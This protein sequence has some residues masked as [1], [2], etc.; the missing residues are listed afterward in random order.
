MASFWQDLRYAFRAFGKSP[1]FASLAVVTL[2]LGIA[3]NTSIFSIINGFLMR[4]MPVPHPEQLTVLSL[5][6]AG[7]KSLQSFS[8]PDYLDLRDQSSSF[9][10]IIA[11][12]V[13][14]AGL[15][16]D[17]RGDHCIATRVTGNYFS[18]LGVQPALGRLILP[19]EGQTPGAD[20]ILVLGYSYWQ[21]RF[22]G[23]K[24]V[25]GKQVEANGHPLT[26]VGVAPKEF[27]G[28]YS[29][30]DSDLYV[31]LS[32]SI[33]TKDEK[34]VENTWMQ[35][36]ERSLS[37]MARLKPGTKL[38]NAQASLDVVAQR[39]AEQ[40]P[41][42]DKGIAIRA[43]PEQLARPEPD[44]DN[45]LPSVAL[46]F[47]ALAALVL[48]VACFN[49][50]NV[51]LVRA[52][53]RQREMAIRAALGAGRV[54]LVRQYLTE[55]LLLALLGA[56]GGMLL[57]YWAM[58]FLSSIPLGT[59]LPLQL[60]FLPD[61]RVYFFALGAALVAGVI[62]GVFPALRVARHDVS[63]VLHDGGRGSSGGRRRQFLRGSLV[64]AQVAGSLV[65]LIVAGLFIRSLG[66]A[67]NIY[68]GFESSQVLDFSLDVQQIG[69]QESQGRAFYR[70]LESR[71]RALPGVVSVAQAFSVP[72]GVMSTFD[73][74]NIERH[75]AQPGQQP[76]S[77]QYNMVTPGY[78]D[79]LHIPVRHG[80]AF[81]ESDE[82]KTLAVA[83]VNQSMAKKFWPDE[84]PLGK[85]FSTKG[86]SGPFIE[87]VGV[88][89][90]GKYKGVI[91]VPQPHF[92]LPLSQAYIPLRTFHIRTAVPPESLSTQVQS[93]VRELAPSLAI[94]EMQTLDQALQG[95]NGFLFFR[96]GAQLTGTMGLLGLILAVVG[97]Y[98]VAS[99]AAVQRTQEI[100]IRMAIGATPGDILKMVLRQGL[101]TVGIGLLA[102]LVAAFAG[103]RL[104]ADLFYGVTPNDPVTYAAVAALLL[105]VVL[106]ACW[107]P[108]RRATRVSPVI[109]LRF[110]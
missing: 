64:V 62:V 28:T 73:S 68:L 79:T 67:Q 47:M 7:D 52:T 21:K 105:A 32:A 74:L 16:A 42:T 93:Q 101:G 17:N 78:F 95:L 107:I 91:E 72:M 92:Y 2:A 8:Y 3:V 49:V 108:A 5:Q 31:P 110:E 51:L 54:R 11:Y 66:K 71:L 99:Y 80:R 77:V 55:S 25:I 103:T 90:D 46:A 27:H 14:L 87:V 102:G 22:T 34:Q 48:L 61:V 36:S 88:V 57:G 35:R 1:W 104:L 56:G 81:T 50:T 97:V 76:P 75:P 65:L 60:K 63:S 41:D 83:V 13:T 86:P 85:R 69:Y 6:Q 39:L 94:S 26:I 98:S 45:T 43:F 23:N 29:I 44:P 96:L 58:R 37:L 40:H 53:A 70:E 89:Q 24:S 4:P 33:G 20:P 30:V 106:L 82:E 9:S 84:D 15:T 12:R 100:G 10:D 18:M 38:K 109:A 59:D 19:T